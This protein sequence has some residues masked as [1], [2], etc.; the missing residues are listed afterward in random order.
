M[1]RPAR[2]K[3]ALPRTIRE[4]ILIKPN[5]FADGPEFSGVAGLTQKQTKE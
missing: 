1:R 2:R 5:E 4:R 3:R